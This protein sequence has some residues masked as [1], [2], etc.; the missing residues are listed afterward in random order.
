MCTKIRMEG[1]IGIGVTNSFYWEEIASWKGILA[2]DHILPL[3]CYIIV[4]FVAQEGDMRVKV[5]AIVIRPT[6]TR[7][8]Q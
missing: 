1:C 2:F 7:G 4:S 3:S 6:S 5:A 8:I